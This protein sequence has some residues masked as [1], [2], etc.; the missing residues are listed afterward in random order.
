MLIGIRFCL[1]GTW[2]NRRCSGVAGCWYAN[3][4][5][6]KNGFRHNRTNGCLQ[7]VHECVGCAVKFAL[8]LWPKNRLWVA[9][10]IALFTGNRRMC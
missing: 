6:S 4:I 8:G 10:R 5:I 3:Q 1:L 9:G 7:Y 2:P